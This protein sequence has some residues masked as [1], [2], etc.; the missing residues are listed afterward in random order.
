M[1]TYESSGG[2]ASGK[3]VSNAFDGNWNTFWATGRENAGQASN[4]PSFLN[5]ITVT[6]S[7]SF[8]AFH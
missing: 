7:P 6:F 8:S 1:M 5:A 4:N 3:A 2:E